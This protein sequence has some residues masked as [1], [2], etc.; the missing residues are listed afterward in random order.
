L[1]IFDL[2]DLGIEYRN[3]IAYLG[4]ATV[5]VA[6][7]RGNN[8]VRE[9]QHNSRQQYACSRDQVEL[10]LLLFTQFFTPR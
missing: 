3:F 1:Q 10:S 4:I 6:Y 7:L 2:L 9:N 8:K 5:L